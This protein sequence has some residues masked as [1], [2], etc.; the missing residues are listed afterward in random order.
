MKFIG[1][2]NEIHLNPETVCD[3]MADALTRAFTKPVTVT[4]VFYNKGTSMF[5]V[6]FQERKKPA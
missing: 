4:S 3:A 6:Q 1:D 5:E 2:D